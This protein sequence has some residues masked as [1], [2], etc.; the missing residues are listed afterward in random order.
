LL[1]RILLCLGQGQSQLVLVQSQ[2]TEPT[3]ILF[4]QESHFVSLILAKVA[5][6][7]SITPL[8]N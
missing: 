2:F 6:V 4:P 3:D 5:V 8:I 1:E 7:P